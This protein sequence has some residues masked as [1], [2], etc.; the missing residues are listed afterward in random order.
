LGSLRSSNSPNVYLAFS[1]KGAHS[2]ESVSFVHHFHPE[3]GTVKHIGPSVEHSA[4]T[5]KDRLVEVETI[6]RFLLSFLSERRGLYLHL[7]EVSGAN[8]VLREKRLTP[9]SL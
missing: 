5:I 2:Y 8:V 3:S 7:R 6:S 9:T 1:S 4:L